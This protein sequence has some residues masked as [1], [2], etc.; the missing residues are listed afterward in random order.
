MSSETSRQFIERYIKA[1]NGSS[2]SLDLVEEYVSDEALKAHIAAFEMAFPGYQIEVHD[3][4]ADGDKVALRGTFRGVHRGEFQSMAPT[5][6]TVAVPL[7]LIYRIAGGRIAEHWMNA[8]ALG[9]L[10]QL[11]AAPVPA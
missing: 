7:M 10:Q 5:G 6:R 1:L 8:D 9:L 3:I 4:L 2:K 11:G